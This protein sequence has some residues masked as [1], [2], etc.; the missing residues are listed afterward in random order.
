MRRLIPLLLLALACSSST[1]PVV[2]NN[3]PCAFGYVR[4]TTA[5]GNPTCVR[6]P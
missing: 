1:E 6:A 3:I 2:D 4:G 5:Q